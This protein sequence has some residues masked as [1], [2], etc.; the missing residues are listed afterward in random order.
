MPGSWQRGPQEASGNCCQHQRRQKSQP[1][2]RC[3]PAAAQVASF[4]QPVGDQLGC[5]K[6]VAIG[7]LRTLSAGTYTVTPVD[8]SFGSGAF[9]AANRISNAN[10]NWT[11]T[12]W[13]SVDGAAPVPHGTATG[14]ASAAAAFGAAPVPFQFTVNNPNI[15]V[16]F[17]WFDNAFGDNQGG[18]SAN[19]TAVPEPGTYAML[20]AGPAAVGFVAKRR[21]A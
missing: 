5:L 19:V 15:A 14:Y 16:S 20:L 3:R 12:L 11:W 13:T 2:P 8:A 10:A 6:C 4:T 17:L 9:T 21:R 7:E 18:I 1:G